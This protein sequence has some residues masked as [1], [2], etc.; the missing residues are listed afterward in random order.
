MTA[1]AA[2]L[3]P[4]AETTVQD[5]GRPGLRHLGV[6]QSGAADRLSFALANAA[7]GNSWDAP[8]LECAS[9]GPTLQFIECAQFALGGADMGATLNDARV[10]PYQ[11]CDAKSGDILKLGAARSGYR[12]YIAFVGGVGGKRDLG[13]VSTYPSAGLGGVDGRPLVAGDKIA[14]AGLPTSQPVALPSAAPSFAR[15]VF[16]RIVS[17]P[18]APLFD[19]RLQK[20]FLT[21]PFIASRRGNRMGVEL[22]GVTIA[23]PDGF[24]MLSSPVFPGTVQCPPSGAP[25]LLLADAQTVGGYARIAQ[26]IDADLHLAGQTRPGNSVWFKGVSADQAQEVAAQ[27]TAFLSAYL[28]GFRFC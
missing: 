3:K 5:A 10:R 19:P 22:G 17:G 15:D 26:V 2:L 6:A 8:A 20:K 28:P 14:T 4:G 21:T 13:S 18:E 23:P 7:A 9:V 1:I 27:R 11:R 25:F 16:L 12:T 24:S